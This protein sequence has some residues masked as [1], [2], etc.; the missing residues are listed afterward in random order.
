MN[1][2]LDGKFFERPTVYIETAAKPTNPASKEKMICAA[3]TFR[4]VDGYGSGCIYGLAR[5]EDTIRA[6]VVERLLMEFT[7]QLIVVCKGLSEAIGHAARS[8]DGLNSARKPLHN[9][10][11]LSGLHKARQRN[12]LHLMEAERLV[13][14]MSKEQFKARLLAKDYL[15]KHSNMDVD[16]TIMRGDEF[17][18]LRNKGIFNCPNLTQRHHQGETFNTSQHSESPILRTNC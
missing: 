1:I 8:A 13:T 11:M 6:L 4:D 18:I 14:D 2:Q 3:Y 10:K 9:Y 7:P 12:D 5:N 16:Q 15:R 17:T